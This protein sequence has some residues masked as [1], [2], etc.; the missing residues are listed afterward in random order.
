MKRVTGFFL[1]ISMLAACSLSRTD[2]YPGKQLAVF[3]ENIRGEYRMHIGGLRAMFKAGQIDSMR[4]RITEDKIESLSEKGNWQTEFAI[5]KDEVLSQQEAY[6]FVSRRDVN[7]PKFWSSSLLAINK[8]E[9]VLHPISATDK[10]LV[11][12]RLKNYLPLKFMTSKGKEGETTSTRIDN[13]NIAL[14]KALSQV[15][16]DSKDTVVYYQM[17]EDA[18]I[19]YIGKELNDRNGLRFIKIKP[20]TK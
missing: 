9:V 10:S 19:R 13:K 5:G 20:E 1:L 6:L 7:E 15:A 4:M 17:N 12:D 18:L 16:V 11:K 8:N 3:P 2:R 14:L